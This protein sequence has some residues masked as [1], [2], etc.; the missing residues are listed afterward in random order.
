MRRLGFYYEPENGTRDARGACSFPRA[1]VPHW[2]VALVAAAFPA[3]RL[4]LARHRRR[5]A[6]RLGLC[7]SCGYDLRA[8]PDRCPECGAVPAR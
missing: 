8:T 6:R 2:V 4:A 1:A 5:R 7:L 3:T